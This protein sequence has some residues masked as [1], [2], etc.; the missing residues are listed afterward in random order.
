MYLYILPDDRLWSLPLD[1]TFLA[2]TRI[3]YRMWFHWMST[4]GLQRKDSYSHIDSAHPWGR[5][6]YTQR[7]IYRKHWCRDQDL[8]KYKMENNIL[9]SLSNFSCTHWLLFIVT[10]ST[11]GWKV[12]D[13]KPLAKILPKVLE[14][15]FFKDAFA[16]SSELT[17]KIIGIDVCFKFTIVKICWESPHIRIPKRW[18]LFWR[19][20]SPITRQTWDGGTGGTGKL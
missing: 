5:T 4:Q 12:E 7:S 8:Q 14:M 20:L 3:H 11:D 2:E 6:L 9:D 15:P 19:N 17:L 18:H 1:C 13:L 10:E 16:F